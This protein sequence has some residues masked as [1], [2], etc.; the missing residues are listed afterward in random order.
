MG[1]LVFKKY[2]VYS[3][4]KDHMKKGLRVYRNKYK[5]YINKKSFHNYYF[6]LNTRKRPLLSIHP[7]VSTDE[8]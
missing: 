4:D 1:S 2:Y 8:K 7:V 3:Y 6:Q 5:T